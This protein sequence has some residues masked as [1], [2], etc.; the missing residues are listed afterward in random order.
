MKVLTFS[1]RWR[2]PD[3]I[4]RYMRKLIPHYRSSPK[5]GRPRLDSRCVADGIYYVMRTGCPWKAAPP[6]FGSGSSLHH[7]FQEWTKHR[8]FRRLW[9]RGLIEYQHRRHIQWTWLALDATMTKSPLGGEK[10]WEKPHRSRQAG[11]QAVDP[12]RWTRRAVGYRGSRSE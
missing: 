3:A 6:Q 10:N 7:Y 4:W 1:K 12:D 8:V 2:L 9:K 5:G 11:H